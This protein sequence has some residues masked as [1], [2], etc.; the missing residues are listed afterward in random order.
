M[1]VKPLAIISR[2]GIRFQE[3]DCA[4]ILDKPSRKAI[5]SSRQTAVECPLSAHSQLLRRD[6]A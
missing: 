2:N 6:S 3:A 5:P 1:G 4:L